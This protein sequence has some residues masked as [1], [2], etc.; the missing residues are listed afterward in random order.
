[1]HRSSWAAL[2]FAVC[3]MFACGS[4]VVIVEDGGRGPA[5]G[6]QCG[7]KAKGYV[8]GNAQDNC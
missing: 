3:A 6:A 7:M 1:M 5:L 2:G 4:E 8:G